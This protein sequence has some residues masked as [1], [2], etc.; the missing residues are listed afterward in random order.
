MIKI[1]NFLFYLFCHNLKNVVF[2]FLKKSYLTKKLC[3]VGLGMENGRFWESL[4]LDYRV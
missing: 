3:K 4:S 2:F 1:V